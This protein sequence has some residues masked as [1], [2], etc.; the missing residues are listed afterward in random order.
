MSAEVLGV[1]ERIKSRQS[2]M[3]M[4]YSTVQEKA[5]NILSKR[6]PHF[7]KSGT[8]LIPNTGT[9]NARYRGPRE[10]RKEHEFGLQVIKDISQCERYISDMKQEYKEAKNGYFNEQ[11]EYLSSLESIVENIH[12][13]EARYENVVERMRDLE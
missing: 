1:I 6:M 3:P 10:S 5:E 8:S 12:Q 11:I 9:W 7:T 2:P 4:G 13:L